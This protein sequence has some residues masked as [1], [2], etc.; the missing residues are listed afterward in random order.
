MRGPLRSK[1]ILAEERKGGGRPHSRWQ[2]GARGRENSVSKI[3]FV[4]VQCNL[5]LFRDYSC[6]SPH[7]RAKPTPRHPGSS[8]HRRDLLL[9]SV[10]EN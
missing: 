3:Y 6:H 5:L 2:A 8:R 10:H 4:A 1:E 9:A 7:C